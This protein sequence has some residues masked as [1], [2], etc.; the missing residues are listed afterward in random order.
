MTSHFTVKYSQ[1]GFILKSSP[2]HAF[3]SIVNPESNTLFVLFC[4][5]TVRLSIFN[6]LRTQLRDGKFMALDITHG[7][8]KLDH[9]IC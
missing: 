1:L 2:T 9:R 4:V 5:T 6:K 7:V 3:R 8:S